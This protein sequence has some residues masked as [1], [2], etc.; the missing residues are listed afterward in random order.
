MQSRNKIFLSEKKCKEGRIFLYLTK[1]WEFS[2][3]NAFLN[4]PWTSV[5]ISPSAN[6]CSLNLHVLLHCL[7]LEEGLSYT[8]FRTLPLLRW[9]LMDFVNSSFLKRC[10]II[11]SIRRSV[12]H[13]HSYKHKYNTTKD[14]TGSV[15]AQAV[16]DRLPTASA[17]VQSQVK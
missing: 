17:R 15:I 12:L 4:S 3:R 5:F 1:E 11:S 2:I 13:G 9:K 14:Y 16:S 7:T 8:S 10:G 6:K